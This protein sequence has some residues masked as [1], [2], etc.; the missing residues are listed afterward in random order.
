MLEQIQELLLTIKQLLEDLP[1]K[2]KVSA[3]QLA[4]NTLSDVA[5]TLG[6]IQAGEFRAGNSNEPGYGFTGT[7]LVYPPVSYNGRL[8][9]LCGIDED[10]FQIGWNSETGKMDIGDQVVTIGQDGITFASGNGLINQDGISGTDLLKWL[11]KQTATQDT[12]TR[13]GKLGMALQEGGGTIPVWELSY[14]SPA[15][16]E[17]IANGGAESGDFT[18]WNKTTETNGSWSISTSYVYSGD[19]SFMWNSTLST[20]CTGVLTSDRYSA[21]AGLSYLFGGALGRI[22]EMDLGKIEIKWYDHASAGNLLQTDLLVSKA[23]GATITYTDAIFKAPTN[24]LSFAIVLT[25]TATGASGYI[26][27]DAITATEIAVSQKLQLTDDGLAT[28]N[29]M[30]PHSVNL[31]PTECIATSALT[32]S[33]SSSQYYGLYAYIPSA[34]ANDGDVYAYTCMLEKGT[35]TL[36]YIYLKGTT[37]GKVDIY[38]DD[39]KV[40]SALDLYAASTTYNQISTTTSIAVT[41]S[42]RHDVHFVIN[43]KNASSSDYTNFQCMTSLVRTGA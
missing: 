42:G 26:Y 2:L 15:G 38:V 41:Y 21:T 20:P 13:T 7:R 3:G 18:A 32:Y 24:A 17:L 39:V 4:V 43:G 34:S 36:K 11:V 19:Y 23:S 22:V 37:C 5:K 16:S 10:G 33:I 27:F 12:Y 40:V 25:T 35:Y 29:G 1:S 31:F 30:Y 6:L 14:E 9:H 28:T 8:Y